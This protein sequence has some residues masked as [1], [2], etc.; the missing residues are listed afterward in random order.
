MTTLE[1]LPREI[2]ASILQACDDFLDL[3]NLFSS[4]KTVHSTWICNQ[5]SI[6]WHVGLRVIPGFSDA[7]IAVRATEIAKGRLRR[8]ELPPAPF[9]IAQLSGNTIKPSLEELKT[10]RR[11]AY[12]AE[13]SAFDTMNNQWGKK[14]DGPIWCL[15]TWETWSEGYHRAFYRLLAAGPILSRAYFEPFVS[16]TKPRGFL[17]SFLQTR[18][19]WSGGVNWFPSTDRAY[20]QSHPLYDIEKHQRWE[21]FFRPLEDL[22][23]EESRRLAR[24]G[25][26]KDCHPPVGT[27]G[28][29]YAIYGS[30]ATDPQ[31]L[32]ARHSEILFNQMLQFT[33]MVEN[34]PLYRMAHQG[35]QSIPSW[36][37]SVSV[38]GFPSFA[39]TKITTTVTQQ[40]EFTGILQNVVLPCLARDSVDSCAPNEYLR[41]QYMEQFLVRVWHGSGVPNYYFTGRYM[42]RKYFGLRFADTMLVYSTDE[43]VSGFELLRKNV[44]VFSGHTFGQPYPKGH[45]LLR[46]VNE[47]VWT[48]SYKDDIHIPYTL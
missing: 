17:K 13:N 46:P 20:I 32:G 2:I 40:G 5:R 6:I 36:S 44:S 1:S 21:S 31:S 42:F 30:Q 19:G 16:N 12:L 29:I 27:D 48:P 22:F 14:G 11:F 41:F 9:P 37:W 8:T 24:L 15:H 25:P 4:C 45:D 3:R 33:C 39:L 47:V 23:V 34:H 7:L 43:S 18:N 10:I 26:V 28:A 35:F 38:I